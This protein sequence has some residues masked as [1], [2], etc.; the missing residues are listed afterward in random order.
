[1][2]NNTTRRLG[3][4]GRRIRRTGP[5]LLEGT[6]A[7][8]DTADVTPGTLHIV[9]VPIGN[10]RDITLRAVDTLRGV[11]LIAAEDTRD[12]RALQR[13]HGITARVV[14]YHDF[15]EQARSRE[16]LELLLAGE[17]LALV[18]D[19]G[20]PLINDPGFRIVNAAIAAGVPVTSLP[21]PCAAVT[22][23]AASGLPAA[24]FLF[25]GFPPRARGKRRAFFDR[26]A[27]EPATLVCYEAP[28]RLL[29][30]L[31]DARD[32]LGD[33]HACLARNLTKPHE[34]YQRGPLSSLLDELA[35]EASVRGEATVVIAGY[36][37]DAPDTHDSAATEIATLLA[38]GAD[39]RT[40]LARIT[41]AHGLKRRDAYDMILRARDG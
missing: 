1:M 3:G 27:R 19:A 34:R 2:M 36:E 40:I 10:P 22:A 30:T 25:L 17:S 15:N 14:S 41:R 6:P 4:S 11:D 31:S 18:A 32:T 23:L 38:A 8:V 7:R 9:A 20:T 13:A 5:G 16:L 26:V 35:A 12:F 28:H 24:P 29:A 33:R 21:G 37:D 39:T